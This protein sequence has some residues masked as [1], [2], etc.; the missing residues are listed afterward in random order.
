VVEKS[1]FFGDL[2]PPSS[3][4][5]ERMLSMPRMGIGRVV[6]RALDETATASQRALSPSQQYSKREGGHIMNH[7]PTF[8]SSAPEM[9]AEAARPKATTVV[10]VGAG[11]TGLTA[12]VRLARFGVPYLILDASPTPTQTSNAALVHASTLELLAELGVANDLVA[13]GREVHSIVLVDAGKV[14]GRVGLTDV[15]SRYPFALGVPQSTTEDLL[16]RT[17]AGWGGSVA[18]EHRAESVRETPDGC[19]I[20]GVARGSIPFEVHARYV[21]GADGS[22]SAVRSAI[23]VDFPGETYASQFVLADAELTS[24]PFADDEAAINMSEL[25]VTV[26]GRLPSGRYRIVASVDGESPVPDAPNRA[27][28]D[29][30]LHDRGIP[31]ELARDP[32]WSSRFR[33]HHRVARRFRVGRVFL[34]GDAAHVHSPAAGQGMNTGIADAYDVAT[35]LAAVLK[36]GAGPSILDGYEH[37]RAAAAAEVV[38]FTD[39]MTRMAT[40]RNPVARAARRLAIPAITRIHPV[41][42]QMTMWITGL[43]RSPL[44]SDLPALRLSTPLDDG[45]PSRTQPSHLRDQRSL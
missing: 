3:E 24:Q 13:A 44:R 29:A 26:F 35:R 27:Y 33:V 15:P 43:K 2:K 34:A 7:R 41:Q 14:M 32:V 17:L 28:I 39:R 4:R 10:I 8:T 42:H 37:D 38:R 21:I 31:V 23:G 12:A 36:C 20:A 25:G 11:P 45:S 16:L 9:E 40:L 22:H 5:P 19:V 18:R 1:A 30:M 6:C